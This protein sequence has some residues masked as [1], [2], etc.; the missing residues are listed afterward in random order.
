MVVALLARPSP[1]TSC[2]F[3][4][5]DTHITKTT[6]EETLKLIAGQ[7]ISDKKFSAIG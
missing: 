7:I 3:C 1:A 2:G 4:R 6:Y 5:G